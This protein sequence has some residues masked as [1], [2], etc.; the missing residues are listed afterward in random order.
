MNRYNTVGIICN[1]QG[2]KNWLISSNEKSRTI[3][4]YLYFE[5]QSTLTERG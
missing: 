2:Q 4:L 5:N 3:F 1:S